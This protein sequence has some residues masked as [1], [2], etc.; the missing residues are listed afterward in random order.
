[1]HGQKTLS[2]SVQIESSDKCHQ[3]RWFIRQFSFM[4]GK[5]FYLGPNS[6]NKR[7]KDNYISPHQD[8]GK[9]LDQQGKPFKLHQQYQNL[10]KSAAEISLSEHLHLK[11]VR[12]KQQNSTESLY[13]VL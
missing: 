6:P 8:T 3:I 9:K 2:E 5:V 10:E 7:K 11:G 12:E 1:M 4:A 13:N